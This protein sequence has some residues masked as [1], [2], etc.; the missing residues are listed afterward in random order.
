MTAAKFNFPE[1]FKFGVAT[2]AYQ[3][4]GAANVDGKGKSIWDTF[5]ETPGKVARGESGDIA[6]DHYNRFE[7]DIDLMREIG[8]QAYRFSFA[9]T[10]MFPNGD[11]IRESRG[12]DFYDR[13]IDKLLAAGIEPFGT[14]Y[15]WDLPQKLQDNGGWVNRETAIRFADYAAAVSEHFGDRVKHLATLNEPWVFTWLGYGLGYHA[16]GLQDKASAIAAAHHSV[17]AHNLALKAIKAVDNTVLVGPVLNQSLPDVDDISD[18]KQMYA[19]Q[20]MDANMNLFWMD[21]HFRGDYPE[22]VWQTY[23]EDLKKVVQPGDLDVV[24]NDWLGINYYF[25]TRV[26]HE[27]DSDS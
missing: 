27:T 19:A 22:I 17:L 9:W 23:G 7:S 5:S 26:G 18:P 2:S 1:N 11:S 10:R 20:L 14:L 6:N 4:E 13:L 21:A 24:K 25:N 16:P 12:I 15:H 8:V 3:I